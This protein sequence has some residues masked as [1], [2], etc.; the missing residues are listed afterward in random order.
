MASLVADYGSSA[1]DS[2]SDSEDE[3]EIASLTTKTSISNTSLINPFR[4]STTTGAK[5][6]NTSSASS[7]SQISTSIFSNPFQDE[8]NAKQSILEQ[9]VKMTPNTES[10]SVINGRQVCWNYRKGRCRFGH[11]CKY[12][13]DSDLV[14]KNTNPEKPAAVTVSSPAFIHSQTENDHAKVEKRKRKKPG[15]SQTLIP[16]KRVIKA[17][18][19][20]QQQENLTAK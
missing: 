18:Y 20:Q 16:S 19:K 13:H 11:N 2:S 12:A 14:P 5:Q 17:Y 3:I 1:S 4:S 7:N 6:T 10:Q 8:E 9:H 15:L